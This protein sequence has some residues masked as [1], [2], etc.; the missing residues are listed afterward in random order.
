MTYGARVAAVRRWLEA[1]RSVHRDRARI[2]EAVAASSGLTAE[3]VELGFS[4]LEQDASDEEIV[5]LV[6]A[7]GEA[8][9]V[10]VILS[11]NVFVAP[12]RA[13]ALARAASSRVTVRP[14]PRDP[15]LARA[16][17]A[18]ACDPAIAIVEEQDVAA[19]ATGEIHVYGRD[20]TI[21]TVRER[22]RA[23]VTVRG[24]G[25]G[26]GLAIVTRAADVGAAAEGL[27]ADVVPFDQR[28]CLSPRVALVEG[29]AARAAAFAGALHERLA[30]WAER[31]PRGRLDAEE[32]R[33]AVRWRDT[34]AFAGRVWAAEDHAVGL[35]G[36]GEA[37]AVPPAGRHVLVAAV[38]ALAE[39]SDAIAPIARFVVAVG[40]DDVRAA[41]SCAPAPARVSALGRMQRPP[42][43][44]PVDRRSTPSSPD[45][46][47]PT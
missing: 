34:M 40:T 8:E 11:A 12:L 45:R 14:S 3:G 29:D 9:R 36:A 21:T 10:H 35:G 26:L 42:L 20:A 16:L 39:V 44:G 47:S 30:T 17:V 4:C 24:H 1:A 5:A 31:V 25:A 19:I 32:R 18:A 7:A 43:D 13:I 28:G 22:A 2:A 46:E 23:G 37:L 38:K 27:A 6:E 41:G 15:V 33:E